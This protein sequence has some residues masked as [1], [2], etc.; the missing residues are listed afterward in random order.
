MTSLISIER[1]C[2]GTTGRHKSEGVSKMLFS[3]F[4]DPQPPNQLLCQQAAYTAIYI[5]VI[6]RFIASLIRIVLVLDMDLR[7]GLR[8]YLFLSFERFR[9]AIKCIIYS[10]TGM[11]VALLLAV[12]TQNSQL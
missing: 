6:L 11:S 1:G 9:I 8:L 3:I 12:S 2:E 4:L 10:I 5:D 7:C